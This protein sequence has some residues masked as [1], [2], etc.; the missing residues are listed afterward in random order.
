MISQIEPGVA[1]LA[2][3]LCMEMDA[4]DLSEYDEEIHGHLKTLEVRELR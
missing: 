1:E 2:R 4:T 3:H